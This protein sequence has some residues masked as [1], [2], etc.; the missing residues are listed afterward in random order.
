M[1]CHG[2]ALQG[3]ENWRDLA[4]KGE[5]AAP[6]L[7]ATGHSWHHSDI[8]LGETL[9]NGAAPMPAFGDVLTDQEIQAVLAYVKSSWPAATLAQQP[10]V[11]AAANVQPASTGSHGNY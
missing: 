7:D 2:D 9:R 5:K 4:A 1:A 11:R 10:Q 6:A 3:Q 8:A